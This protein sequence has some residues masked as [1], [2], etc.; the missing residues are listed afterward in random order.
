LSTSL[1]DV[2]RLVAAVAR[3][4]SGEP[5]PVAYEQDPGTGDFWPVTDASGWTADERGHGTPCA[6]G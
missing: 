6:R 3:I 1:A 4:A 5:A 2:E